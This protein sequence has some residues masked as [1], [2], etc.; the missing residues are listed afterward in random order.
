MAAGQLAGGLAWLAISGEDAPDLVTTAPVPPHYLIRAKIEGVLGGVG[1]VFAPLVAAIAFIAPFEAAVIAA[2]MAAA[3][4]SA[5][6]IQLW[7]RN[8]ARRSHFRRRHVSSRVATYAEAFSSIAWAAT[9]ALASS[10][11]LFAIG[12]AVLGLI[13]LMIA[14]AIRPRG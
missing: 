9:A 3:V 13:V 7:F 14:R 2:G 1:I 11:S 4:V 6:M 5:T 10:E 8:Q 12:P